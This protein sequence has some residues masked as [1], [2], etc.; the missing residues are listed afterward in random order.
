MTTMQT[1]ETTTTEEGLF[2]F[3]KPKRCH[4]CGSYSV[5]S[6]IVSVYDMG[7]GDMLI[8]A[9]MYRTVLPPYS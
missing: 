8:T 9:A 1:N 3:E 7:T 5:C 4:C 6:R 2:R